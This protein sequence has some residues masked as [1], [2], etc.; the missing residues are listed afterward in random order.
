MKLSGRKLIPGGVT[1]RWVYVTLIP[2]VIT[3]IVACIAV[4]FAFRRTYYFSAEQSMKFRIAT[5][6]D[7]I[8]SS[9]SSYVE[10]YRNMVE[11]VENFSEKDRYELMVLRRDGSVLLTSSGFAYPDELYRDDFIAAQ[12]SDSG[13]GSH[14]GDSPAG[15]H[16][17]SATQMLGYGFGDAAAVRLVSSLK[18]IDG[19]LLRNVGISV[20]V[21]L[22]LIALVSLTGSLYIASL[23]R[24]IDA[25]GDTAKLVAA[26]QFDTR[27]D[28]IYSGEFGELCDIVND[29][30]AELQRTNNLKNDFVSSISHELRT[31]LTSIKGW[32]DTISNVST[33][34]ELY[35]RGLTIISS[36]TERLSGLVEDLLDF[37]RLESKRKLSNDPVMLDLGAELSDAVLTLE[38][39]AQKLG[40]IVKY[41]EP[42]EPVIVD[43]D[44]N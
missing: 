37:S 24:P 35:Q 18:L 20:L 42:D 5:T 25:I 19:R 43:A 11:L 44:K 40:I 3:V 28:N 4:F 36:E 39:R 38:Q 22:I 27:I 6:V 21:G 33:D 29:M 31:P 41:S 13:Y 7:S 2:T 12:S 17:I 16:I 14:I 9:G 15:E 32:S 23:K 30:A 1:E 26:G 10:R 8:P 34:D